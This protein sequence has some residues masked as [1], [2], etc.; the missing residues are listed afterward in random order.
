MT[1]SEICERVP[2]MSRWGVMK[3]LGLLTE[4][5]LIQTLPEGRRRRHFPEQ[6][7]LAPLRTWLE[8]EAG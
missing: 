7:G 6:G 2:G 1:T 4:A 3:H 8:E 5:G